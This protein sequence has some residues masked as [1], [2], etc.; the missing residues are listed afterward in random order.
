MLDLLDGFKFVKKASKGRALSLN[1][2]ISTSINKGGRNPDGSQRYAFV[3]IIAKSVMQK[4]GLTVGDK[5]DIGFKKEDGK[6][7]IFM[8]KSQDGYTLTATGANKGDTTA[9]AIKIQKES[10]EDGFEGANVP[11]EDVN[12]IFGGLLIEVK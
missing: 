7:Y 10:V 11:L 12:M 5:L 1:K 9:A 3:V 4:Y 6:K 2:G 8:K